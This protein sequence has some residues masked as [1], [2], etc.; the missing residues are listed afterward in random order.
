[1]E[2]GIWTAGT[3]PERLPQAGP[4]RRSGRR[5]QRLL[6]TL[7]L[8]SLWPRPG[9]AADIVVRTAEDRLAPTFAT[10]E[11]LERDATTRCGTLVDPAAFPAAPSLR[12]ALIYA[13]HLPGPD[14]ITFVPA[15]RGQTLVVNFDGPDAGAEA[16]PLPPLCGGAITVNGDIDGDGTPDITLDGSPLLLESGWG[17]YVDSD[18]NTITG[19]A[20]QNFPD[21]AITVGAGA[22][23][24]AVT[25]NQITHNTITGGTLGVLVFA[26]VTTTG[27][28]AATTIS[29]NTVSGASFAGILASAA[30]TGSVL[31]GT[32]ITDNVVHQNGQ[33]GIL[34][35]LVKRT[36]ETPTAMRLTTTTI[37]GNEVAAHPAA[38][39]VVWNRFATTSQLTQLR[40]V[41]NHVFENSV[42][43]RVGG[44]Y[45]GATGN[46]LEG[47]IARNTLAQNL[48]GIDV[49]GATNRY[50][51][52]E[53]P[54]SPAT[55]NH[56]TLAI[57]DNV[58]EEVGWTGIHILGGFVDAHHNTVTA[59]LTGNTVRGGDHGLALRG[60][61]AN[62]RD[63]EGMEITSATANGNT[64]TATLTANRL[65]GARHT[66]LDVVAGGPGAASD[67]TVTV[68][69]V[70]NVVCGASTSFS[71]LGGLPNPASPFWANAGTGN[72]V[73]ATLTAN[74]MGAAYV[75]DG[76]VGN[77]VRLTE[78]GTQGCGRTVENPRAGSAQSGIGVLSGWVCEAEAITVEF[79]HGATEE[80]STFT[81]GYGTSR[82]DTLETCGDTDNGFSLLFNWNLLGDGM[83]TV[84]VLA[85][86]VLFGQRSVRVSSLGRGE[87][88]TGL[89]GTYPLPDFPHMGTTTSIRWEESL[90]NFVLAIG[91][92]GGGGSAGAAPQVLENPSPGSFQSG[93]GAIT[94]WVCEAEAITIA[95]HHGTTGAVSTF[96]AGYGTSRADTLAACGDADN[97]FSL[98]F[99]W[100]LLGDGRH[101]VRALADGVE[102]ATVTVTVSTLDGEFV[103]GL[104]R[105][106]ALV[107]FPSAG[108]ATI[109]AW[110]ESLQNFVITGVEAAE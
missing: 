60:G 105:A 86:G 62:Y 96:T 74:S 13:N 23:T 45:C 30:V 51:D 57:T 5:L 108:H 88:A 58:L 93:L 7:L 25:G 19:V 99:N 38:G 103:T 52:G 2:S 27:T 1:M 70:T 36:G 64:V 104:D 107:D 91:V 21:A 55:H 12:E 59:T 15:L 10:F 85:D 75:H 48:V 50:C 18:H 22:R 84:R 32:R 43:I 109:V 87:F 14:T 46:R 33:A 9:F 79:V 94:G 37:Q 65:E 8:L 72:A 106:F 95:F 92:G 26:G 3:T 101:T 89:H 35:E 34:V 4:P 49:L 83:H 81:A 39:I 102:F 73:T 54:R 41:E 97:G 63:D 66:E 24:A 90:Q 28:V 42:G 53:T 69:A 31:D 40:L 67:N 78:T 98:L 76:V 47:E 80:V 110:E 20:L 17:L 56:M 11:I 71:G 44:G 82:A 16:D 100:N 77:T 6:P 61:E 68:T 29:D